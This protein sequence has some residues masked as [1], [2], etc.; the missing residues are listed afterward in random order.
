MT[1]QLSQSNISMLGFLL[2]EII[3][4]RLRK[5]KFLLLER[6][7]RG[8]KDLLNNLKSQYRREQFHSIE[9]RRG[10]LA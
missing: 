9:L 10:C 3:S 6:G 1:I 8:L 5:F 7:I 4:K 2:W